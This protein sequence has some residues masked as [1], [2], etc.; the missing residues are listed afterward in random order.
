MDIIRYSLF[1]HLSEVFLI[2]IIWPIFWF[3]ILALRIIFC[4]HFHLCLPFSIHIEYKKNQ[5]TNR[6]N[7]MIHFLAVI[8]IEFVWN[9]YCE[10]NNCV[11]RIVLIEIELFCYICALVYRS[12]VIWMPADDHENS[13]ISSN[14]YSIQ[15]EKKQETTFIS[16]IFQSLSSVFIIKYWLLFFFSSFFTHWFNTNHKQ[17]HTKLFNTERTHA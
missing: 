17:T 3:V 15:I 1:V 10:Y 7:F 16:L 2:K 8:I 14:I 9:I 11:K 5:L 6:Y 13:S 4:F 12:S